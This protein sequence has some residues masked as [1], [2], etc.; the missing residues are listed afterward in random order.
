MTTVVAD[1]EECTGLIDQI[2]R[3]FFDCGQCCWRRLS[4]PNHEIGPSGRD[5][6]WFQSGKRLLPVADQGS[7]LRAPVRADFVAASS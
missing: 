5:C 4:D 3:R 7:L 2:T 6:R 1:S